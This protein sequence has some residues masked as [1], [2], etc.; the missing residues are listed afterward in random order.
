MTR[1]CVAILATGV[2]LGC[3][4]GVP[5]EDPEFEL[6]VSGRQQALEVQAGPAGLATLDMG[7]ADGGQT[8]P[9]GG[10]G[11]GSTAYGTVALP[12]DPIPCQPSMGAPWT[13]G[14]GPGPLGPR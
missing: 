2:V 6:T 11:R 1:V 14:F 9:N 8:Q 3:G 7:T 4:A 13:P 12:Q 5:G 10:V